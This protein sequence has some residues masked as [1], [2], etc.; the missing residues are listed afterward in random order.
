MQ[1]IILDC[2]LLNTRFQGTDPDH[3][4]Q[5]AM[6]AEA[7][8]KSRQSAWEQC[9]AEGVQNKQGRVQLRG[10]VRVQ[11]KGTDEGYSRGIHLRGAGEL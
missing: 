4:V 3:V 11:W 9:T 2:F 8:C 1:S 10:T 6:K 7:H 5:G